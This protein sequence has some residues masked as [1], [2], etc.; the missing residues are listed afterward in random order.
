MILN[1]FQILKILDLNFFFTLINN[2]KNT[3][4]IQNIKSK[5]D[6]EK[7]I[8]EFYNHYIKVY[9]SFEIINIDIMEKDIE[10]QKIDYN[11]NKNY[12]LSNI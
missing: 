2:I 9:R 6:C 5:N 1:F 11:R 10:N 4:V 7:S 3:K 8:E 12:K